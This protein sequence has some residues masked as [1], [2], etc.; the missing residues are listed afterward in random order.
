MLCV[1]IEIL[2]RNG[3]APGSGFTRKRQVTVVALLRIGGSVVVSTAP[4]KQITT[5][6]IGFGYFWPHHGDRLRM[7]HPRSKKPKASAGSVSSEPE[8]VSAQRPKM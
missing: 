4:D 3:I 7:P 5:D 8:S 6:D 1:L 2:G